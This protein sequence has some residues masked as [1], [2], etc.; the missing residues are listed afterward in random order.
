MIPFISKKNY[1]GKIE[2]GR[3]VQESLD[4]FGTEY[5]KEISLTE[6]KAALVEYSQGATNNKILIRT[7][8]N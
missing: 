8:A 4:V 1:E 2:V 5:S 7:R 6:V 3:Q